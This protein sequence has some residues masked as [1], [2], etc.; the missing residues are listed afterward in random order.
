[1]FDCQIYYSSSQEASAHYKYAIENENRSIHQSQTTY[2]KFIGTVVQDSITYMHTVIK[3]HAYKNV[4]IQSVQN[5]AIKRHQG[6]WETFLK[7]LGHK[8]ICI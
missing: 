2:Q 8:P 3:A 1:M 5:P 7:M 6:K 4:I